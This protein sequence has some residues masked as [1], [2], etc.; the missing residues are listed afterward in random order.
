MK[1]G[2]LLIVDDNRGILSA[3]K[4]L[5]DKHLSLIHI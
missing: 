4:L 1:E 3:V 2:K 5:A